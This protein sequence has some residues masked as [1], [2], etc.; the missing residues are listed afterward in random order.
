MAVVVE[1]RAHG[2]GLARDHERR[3]PQAGVS[4]V[5]ATASVQ[6]AYP[7]TLH[8]VVLP[9]TVKVLAG[10]ITVF[11]VIILAF[12][13]YQIK[14]WRNKRRRASVAFARSDEQGRN[15][16]TEKGAGI[17]DDLKRPAQAVLVPTTPPADPDAACI[18][19]IR[20]YHMPVPQV[21]KP[22]EKFKQMRLVT[23]HVS[24]SSDG[25]PPPS[26]TTPRKQQV[27]PTSLPIGKSSTHPARGNFIP[28]SRVPT[29]LPSAKSPII[30]HP[31]EAP[32][33][34]SQTEF[35]SVLAV[36]PAPNASQTV[37]VDRSPPNEAFRLMI[38]MYVF[39]PTL[40]D[41]LALNIGETVRL[42]EE[43]RDGWCLV[44]HI[45]RSHRI[46]GVVPRFCLEDCTKAPAHQE[47]LAV[48]QA[49]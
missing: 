15:H 16:D 40:V 4:S 6:S 1:Y 44:Q 28:S 14:A 29:D 19:K 35:A 47:D 36:K 8:D 25:S 3:S 11:G 45:S 22:V 49:I 48:P 30:P 31:Y 10:V 26:Y 5:S 38:V 41:E 9:R 42:L 13:A 23:D 27:T 46:R 32:Q 7:T 20:S 33:V 17:G 37:E 34:P 18:S 21:S 24:V 39:E 12:T 2:R 43:Y